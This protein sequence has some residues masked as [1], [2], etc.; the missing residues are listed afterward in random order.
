M[1]IGGQKRA[2]KNC[3][4]LVCLD[5]THHLTFLKKSI[6]KLFTDAPHLT[7]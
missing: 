2:N 7:L 3:L 1:R 5:A 4:F 6:K